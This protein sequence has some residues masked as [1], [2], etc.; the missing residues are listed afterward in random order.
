M[1]LT[2]YP[3]ILIFRSG[4][5]DNVIINDKLCGVK[6]D[7]GNILKIKSAIGDQKLCTN[8]L[9]CLMIK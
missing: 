3:L 6:E 5:Q 7:N 4:Q 1:L 9:V 8:S 2:I